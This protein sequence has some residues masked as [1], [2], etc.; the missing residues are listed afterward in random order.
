[1]A[2][3]VSSS[4]AAGAFLLALLAHLAHADEATFDLLLVGLAGLAI[5]LADHISRSI[6]ASSASGAELDGE[7]RNREPEPRSA[8]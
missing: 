8:A 5:G 7:T 4:L 2:G 1:M 6:P 3:V